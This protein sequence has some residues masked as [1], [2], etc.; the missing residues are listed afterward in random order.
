[1]SERAFTIVL[2][3]T[4]DRGPLL[5]LVVAQV[6]LQTLSDW[7]LFII[8]DGVNQATRETIEQLCT[9]DSRLRF[10]DHPKHA[11]RGEPRRHRALSEARGRNVAYLCD[12]DLWLPDHLAHLESALSDADWAHTRRLTMRPQGDCILSINCDLSDPAQ[13]SFIATTDCCVGMSCVGHRLQSYRRLPH[14]WRETPQG[15]KT[16]HYM[17]MQFLNDPSNR[18]RSVQWPTVLYYNRGAHP[19]WPT[20]QRHAELKS[21]LERLPD[22]EAQYRFREQQVRRLNS[23]WRRAHHGMR[24]WFWWHPKAHRQARRFSRRIPGL[25]KLLGLPW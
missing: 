1:M 3:T 9:S 16:D 15:T 21:W 8:G 2:P 22:A 11:R 19:G 18:L 13:R 17:W 14:G 7:E 5:P 20:A 12:R 23:P 4:T 25:G 24:S 10:F 6:Q